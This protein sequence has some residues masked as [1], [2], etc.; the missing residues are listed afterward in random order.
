MSSSPVSIESCGI[1]FSSCSVYF[2]CHV[3]QP[4]T[5]QV[6]LRTSLPELLK[7]YYRCCGVFNGA[8]LVRFHARC[9]AC[10]L[11]NFGLCE[12]DAP[13]Q[14]RDIIHSVQ[15]VNLL[16]EYFVFLHMKLSLWL[17]GQLETS[18]WSRWDHMG[19]SVHWERC[20]WRR[21]RMSCPMK[22][23]RRELSCVC[24]QMAQGPWLPTSNT[25]QGTCP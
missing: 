11:P 20:G 7:L 2:G 22:E 17:V 15:I 21:C 18:Y 8:L 6:T 1:W 25:L 14:V 23:C 16:T 13:W 4:T 3:Q 5:Q 9:C 19:A 24:R 10:W 12:W